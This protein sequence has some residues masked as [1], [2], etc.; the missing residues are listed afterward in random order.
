MMKLV[1]LKKV[2]KFLIYPI[3]KFIISKKKTPTYYLNK[4][5]KNT[6][7]TILQI[8]SNDGSSND[9]L[10]ELIVKNYSWKVI[11]V[12]PVPYLFDK[13]IE[14]YTIESRFIFE[15]LAINDGKKTSF[16][17]VDK[18]AK[19]ELRNLPFWY[20]QLGSFNREH[21]VN[22]LNGILEP[23][24]VEISVPCMNLN[25]LLEKHKIVNLDLFHIDTEG[26]DYK[27]LSQL[28]FTK[29]KPKFI[30]FEHKHLNDL[31]KSASIYFLKDFYYIFN[32]EG[33]SLCVLKNIISTFDYIKLDLINKYLKVISSIRNYTL[34]S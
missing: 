32:F 30:L 22:Q 23:Y 31:E 12:E 15:N 19:N 5:L 24:I 4:Y 1:S 26:Y 34:R 20:D 17:Y 3:H 21:I 9:P 16:Y 2:F 7:F 18:I 27:I 13:L 11:F 14:N 25:Q 33:D 29:F 6:K 28:N 10:F 8:G